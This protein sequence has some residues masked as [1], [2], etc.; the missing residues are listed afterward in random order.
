VDL[1][2]ELEKPATAEQIN[3]AFKAAA[4]GSRACGLLEPTVS[5]D[6]NHDPHSAIFDA[7]ST[8]VISDTFARCS[9]GTTTNGA[10]PTVWWTSSRS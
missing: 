6:Y 9:P 7:T 2:V 1:T 3:A 10:S 5:V 8:F 4:G